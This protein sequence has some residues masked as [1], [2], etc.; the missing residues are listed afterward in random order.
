VKWAK[1]KGFV[2]GLLANPFRKTMKRELLKEIE[3]KI[4]RMRIKHKKLRP[5]NAYED[6]HNATL[7]DILALMRKVK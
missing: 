7:D 5:Y 4:E 2:D 6:V 3:K 1:A